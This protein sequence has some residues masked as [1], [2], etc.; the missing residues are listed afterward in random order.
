VERGTEGD[1]GHGGDEVEARLLDIGRAQ[2]DQHGGDRGAEEGRDPVPGDRGSP[3]GEEDRA[4]LAMAL[5]GDRHVE[6]GIGLGERGGVEAEIAGAAK[7]DATDAEQAI[8]D[9]KAGLPAV[10]RGAIRPD[11]GVA[12]RIARLPGVD[13]RLRE[14]RAHDLAHVQREDDEPQRD[15]RPEEHLVERREAPH[16]SS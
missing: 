16:R 7:I 12:V 10:Q 15:E 4:L 11:G 6:R 1:E 14:S 2:Q 5:D 8:A 13:R 3:H 9:L